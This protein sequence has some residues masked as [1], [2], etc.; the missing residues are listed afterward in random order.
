MEMLALAILVL[1]YLTGG[2]L[3]WREIHLGI[4]RRDGH[5]RAEAREDRWYPMRPNRSGKTH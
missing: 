3:R 2:V 4:K 1:L 5:A